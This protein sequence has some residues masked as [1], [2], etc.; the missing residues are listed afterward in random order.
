MFKEP[1]GESAIP[2]IESITTNKKLYISAVNIANDGLISNLSEDIILENSAYFDKNGYHGV[3]IGNIP[4]DLAAILRIEA[5]VQDL[6]VEAI[7]KR[8][9]NLA[10]S[11]LAL[12]PN[13]GS[14]KIAEQIFNGMY[15]LQKEFLPKFR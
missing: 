15:I 6:C 1:S 9:K 10:I 4:K 8:S 13:V 7:L 5:T 3:K 2:I 12:D 14:F 11:C